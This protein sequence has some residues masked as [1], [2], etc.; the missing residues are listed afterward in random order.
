MS[1]D[2][3]GRSMSYGDRLIVSIASRSVDEMLKGRRARV[4]T[5]K[6]KAARS[7]TLTLNVSDQEPFAPGERA[8]LLP[9]S[10]AARHVRSAPARTKPDEARRVQ[11]CPGH[12]PDAERHPARVRR[13]QCPLAEWRSCN[14]RS[15]RA[16]RWWPRRCCGAQPACLLHLRRAGVSRR[17]RTSSTAPTWISPACRSR[18]QSGREPMPGSSSRAHS[19]SCY[20]GPSAQTTN[21]YDSINLVLF[22]NA[23]SGPA[24]ATTYSW[25]IGSRIVDADIVFWDAA[26]Q[27]FCGL[28]RVFRRLL[29]RGHRRSRVRARAR[30]R[31]FG[32]G[33]RDDVPVGE[34]VQHRPPDARRR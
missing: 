25:S 8:V 12:Q 20:G 7:A 28:E 4:S 2:P 21:T 5:S 33:E 26:F 19:A 30:P 9:P 1:V 18:A 14:R 34:R 31:A 32:I 22:R 3:G 23:S 29:H 6:S 17:C 27:F 24:I 13:S 15:H 11:P 16:W 10:N